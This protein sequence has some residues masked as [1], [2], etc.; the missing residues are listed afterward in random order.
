ML[1]KKKKINGLGTKSAR[2]KLPITSTLLFIR[3][4]FSLSLKYSLSI[5]LEVLAIISNT[6][7]YNG[8]L[9]F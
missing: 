6:I 2:T 7:V 3:V 5:H 1:D 9:H 4:H 8:D